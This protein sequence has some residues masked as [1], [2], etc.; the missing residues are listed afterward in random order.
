L[1][2]INGGLGP[3]RTS[4]QFLDD[5]AH[6][7][8][9]VGTVNG[10]PAILQPDINTETDPLGNPIPNNP[11]LAPAYDNELLDKHFITGDGRGNEN[12]GL[13]TVH[14]V[15][16]AEHNRQV[17]SVKKQILEIASSGLDADIAFLNE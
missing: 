4:H 13:T 9:P 5:I 17:D 15:F 12:I 1:A 10:Q 3:V 2:D 14:H 6:N 8:N 16:H 11:D 7:A